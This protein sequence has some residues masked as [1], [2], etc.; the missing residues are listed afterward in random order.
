MG[1]RSR[2]YVLDGLYSSSQCLQHA[3]FNE[4]IKQLI[5]VSS[6]RHLTAT[7][8]NCGKR[9]LKSEKKKRKTKRNKE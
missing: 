2:K 1:A 3:T 9:K 6:P 5:S 8:P 4:Q 7:M